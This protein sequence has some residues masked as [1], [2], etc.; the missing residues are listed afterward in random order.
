MGRIADRL[1]SDMGRMQ[2]TYVTTALELEPAASPALGDLLI[3][4]LSPSHDGRLGRKQEKSDVNDELT[5]DSGQV[6]AQSFRPGNYSAQTRQTSTRIVVVRGRE[7]SKILHE[8]APDR[9]AQV[10]SG[11]GS[12]RGRRGTRK[13]PAFSERTQQDVVYKSETKMRR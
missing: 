6:L 1:S 13:G 5:L 11:L 2:C 12:R 8:A 4:G 9:R 10:R 3:D 7:G